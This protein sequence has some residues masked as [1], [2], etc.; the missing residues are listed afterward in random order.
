[1]KRRFSTQ[2]KSWSRVL[3]P[4]GQVVVA[5]LVVPVPVGREG[6]ERS[7]VAAAGERERVRERTSE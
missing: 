7:V 6:S 1:M 2:P 5:R 3:A 4:A